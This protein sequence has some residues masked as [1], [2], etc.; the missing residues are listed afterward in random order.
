ME[1]TREPALSELLG[2][3]IVQAL[4]AADRVEQRDLDVL[5][6]TVRC[7]RR[8]QRQPLFCQPAQAPG[9]V[10]IITMVL[11][12]ALAGPATAQ[13]AGVAGTNLTTGGVISLPAITATPS[14]STPAAVTTFTAPTSAGASASTASPA[15]DDERRRIV[16]GGVAR[17]SIQYS[18]ALAA[19][20]AAGGFGDGTVYRRHQSFLRA[21]NEQ[22]VLGARASKA[23]A[24]TLRTVPKP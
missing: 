24:E 8:R 22:I 4:M 16:I 17:N 14:T 3:P 12:M 1:W 2:D 5:F 23:A 13:T 20:P 19:V 7:Q 10:M 11:L 21:L 9:K 15:T 18:A 6:A